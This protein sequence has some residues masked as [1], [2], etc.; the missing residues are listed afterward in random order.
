MIALYIWKRNEM[1]FKRDHSLKMIIN[2]AITAFFGFIWYVGLVVG[3]SM[4]ITSHA[5]VMYSST[6]VYMLAFTV[7]TGALVHKFELYGYALFFLGVFL[8]FTDPYAIKEGGVGNQY[9]GDLIT[10][11]GA[12]SGAILGFYNSRNSKLIHPIVI[13]NHCFVFSVLFQTS[14]ACFMLGAD[15]VL[16]FDPGYGVLGWITDKDTFWFLVGIVAPFNGMTCNIAFY[17]SYYFFPMEIIAGAILT[18]PF[19]A[20]VVGVLLG[21]DKIPGFRTI[22]GLVIITVGTLVSSYGSRV[23]AVEQVEKL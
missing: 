18:E 12:G 19:I 8:M 11:L 22:F 23:K 21:Q 14:F 13:M 10:F 9:V 2:S 4:T 20:Q 7:L 15:R 16:S 6:G 1:S 3:C 17:V 5:M